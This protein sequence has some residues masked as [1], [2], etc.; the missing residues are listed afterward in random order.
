MTNMEDVKRTVMAPSSACPMTIGE[1]LS[2]ELGVNE[3]VQWIWCH[4][5][6]RGSS[7][8]GYS[9][10]PREPVEIPETRPIGFFALAEK[11]W[12]INSPASAPLS[13]H[14]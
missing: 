2:V 12:G 10:A 7:V 3:D 5:G 6:D 11:R 4:H 9:V 13:P 8:I 14:Q 1:L